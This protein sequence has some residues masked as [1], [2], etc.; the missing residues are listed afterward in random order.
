MIKKSW[1]VDFRVE[2]RHRK[3]SPENT[4]AGAL[5]Y[6]AVLRGKL[7]RGESIGKKEEEKVQSRETTF[8]EFA[9]R[10]FDEYVMP[11]SKPSTQYSRKGILFRSLTPFF[12]KMLIGQI[13]VSDVE[14]YKVHVK[15]KGLANRTVNEH[16][17]VLNHCVKTAYEWLRLDGAPPKIT[18]LKCPP[19][20][21]DYLSFDESELLLRHAD[22]VTLELIL[23]ALKTGMRLG[24]LIGLQWSSID[25]NNRF[26][27]V[28]HSVSNCSKELGSP[29][30][31]RERHVDMTTDLHAMLH[32]RKKDTGYVFVDEKGKRFDH[33]RLGRILT[34]VCKKAKLRHIGWHV[35]RHSFASHLIMRGA[36]VPVVQKLLG[37]SAIE[38]TMRYAHLAPSTMRTAIDLLNH[39][40]LPPE[41]FGQPVGNQWLEAQAR[42]TAQKS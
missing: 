8:E 37:H 22:G 41:S 9:Q 17:I 3:K 20:V 27:N 18:W 2:R 6:E 34:N 38:M 33:Y 35:L 31:N 23:T 13:T 32:K 1:W 42:E 40:W 29:K 39:T 25:W 16:L 10:W 14:K 26:V 36:P 7:A 5:A 15:K 28:R 12:G 30:S 24:E 11:N 21:T 4:R 19:P